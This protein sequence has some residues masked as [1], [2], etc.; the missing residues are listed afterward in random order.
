MLKI[1]HKTDK[2]ESRELVVEVMNVLIEV[3]ILMISE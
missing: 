2:T 1:A 3:F